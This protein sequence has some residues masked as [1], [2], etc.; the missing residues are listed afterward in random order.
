MAEVVKQ[1]HNVD[2][3]GLVVEDCAA[4]DKLTEQEIELKTKK[5]LC[6]LYHSLFELKK[7]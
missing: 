1:N 7:A 5:N 2:I 6:G 3:G 4:F